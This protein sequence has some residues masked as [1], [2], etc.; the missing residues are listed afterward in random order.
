MANPST[1][2]T[3]TKT[4][5]NAHTSRPR[6][7]PLGNEEAGTTLSLGEF[8]DDYALSTS[9]ARLLLNVITDR[10]K[11]ANPN[12]RESETLARTMDHLDTFARIK[13][14]S[15]VTQLETVLKNATGLSTF[16][17][18]QLGRSLSLRT[19]R[20]PGW[21]NREMRMGWGCDGATQM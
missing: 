3:T 7:S 2:T 11:K 8:T 13:N 12:F 10:E 5:K 4:P 9:E 16:E 20:D 17:K 14:E 6:Q 18:S 15:I 1:S 21:K 19:A